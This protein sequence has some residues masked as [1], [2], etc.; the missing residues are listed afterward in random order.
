MPE[1]ERI[2]VRGD[3]PEETVFYVKLAISPRLVSCTSRILMDYESFKRAV[4]DSVHMMLPVVKQGAWNA[5]ITARFVALSSSMRVAPERTRRGLV[6]TTIDEWIKQS[7]S[8][9]PKFFAIGRPFIDPPNIYLSFGE[10]GARLRHIQSN[11]TL[12]Q[13]AKFLEDGG[14]EKTTKVIG[15]RTHEN[16]WTRAIEHGTEL[17][18]ERTDVIKEVD[19]HIV[20][21]APK[22]LDSSLVDELTWDQF[23]PHEEGLLEA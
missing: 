17:P 18:N 1:I 7:A 22:G 6:S 21:D 16:V 11:I 4:L 23:D 10:L 14:W 2:E 12:P 9:D 13:V 20:M 19:G 8:K 15:G 5:Y 3:D